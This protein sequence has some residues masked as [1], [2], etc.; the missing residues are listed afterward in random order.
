M[1]EDLLI[2]PWAVL[3][4]AVLGMAVGMLWYS[5]LVF[6]KLWE[7][8]SGFS[9]AAIAEAKKGMAKTLAGAFLNYLLMSFVLAFFLDRVGAYDA[10]EGLIVAGMLWFGFIT[11]VLFSSVLWER[12]PLV[13]FMVNAGHYVV[14][15]AGASVLIMLFP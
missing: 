10:V 12:K 5:P 2:N 7:R 11:T 8:L 13:L 14:F 3:G 6:G 1:F 9:E 4:S 15:L